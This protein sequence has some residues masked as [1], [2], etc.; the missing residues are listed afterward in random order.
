MNRNDKESLENYHKQKLVSF[1]IWTIENNRF[2]GHNKNNL[3][4][5]K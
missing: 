1:K 4:E 2:P 5:M 3:Q